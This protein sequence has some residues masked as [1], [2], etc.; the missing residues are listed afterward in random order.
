[1]IRMFVHLVVVTPIAFLEW[2]FMQSL[3]YT[4]AVYVGSL[5]ISLLVAGMKRVTR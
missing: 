2:Y 5:F 4:A 3:W 1:M